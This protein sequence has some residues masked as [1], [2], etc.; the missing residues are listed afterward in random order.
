M[1]CKELHFHFEKPVGAD[2]DIRSA[3]LTEHILTCA[4]CSRFVEGQK[5]LGKHLRL[6]RDSSPQLSASLDGAVLVNYRKYIEQ[7][8]TTVGSTPL[9]ER[10]SL[11]A[12]L[13]WSG[14]V[15][16][17]MLVTV[18]LLWPARRTVT[19]VAQPRATQPATVP[20]PPNTRNKTTA[21]HEETKPTG[22]NAPS[23]LAR[24]KPASISV[25]AAGGSFLPG[26]RSL[27]YCDQ[28]S[29]AEAMEIIRVQLPTSIAGHTPASTQADGTVFADVLVGADGIARGIR[30]VQ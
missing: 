7:L 9:R 10:I 14:A 27:M 24:R 28:L 12:D 11:L 26:F 13:R 23:Y 17:A 3:E 29:C 22:P 30:I 21:L 8:A 19:T 5:E 15:A 4:E 20:Q 1:T 18:I 16:A 6:V 25:A 2:V